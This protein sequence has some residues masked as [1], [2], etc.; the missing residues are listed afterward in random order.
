[1]LQRRL[2]SRSAALLCSAM[3]LTPIAVSAQEKPMPFDSIKAAAGDEDP[4]D[5]TMAKLSPAMKSADI[6]AAIKKVADWQAG[7]SQAKFNQDWTYAPLYLGLLAASKTTGDAKYHDAV[8]QASEKFQ[9]KLWAT[10]QFHAD[11]EAIGQAYEALYVEKKDPVRIADTKATFDRLLQRPDDPQKDLWWWCDALFM[12]PAGM[13]RMSAITGN[14]AYLDKMDHEWNLTTEHL[15][16]KGEH[17]YFRDNSYIGKTEKNGQKIFWGRGNGW[18]LGGLANTIT[19][20]DKNDPLRPKYVALFREMSERVAGLQQPDGLWH[21]GLLDQQ[22]YALPEISGSAFFTYAFAWGVNQG[23]LDRAK[24]APVV[25]KAWA[26]M[27]QHVYADGRLGCI[28]PIGAAPGAFGPTSSY[29]YGVG[30]F[31]LAGAE[32]DRMAAHGGAAAKHGK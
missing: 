5:T 20:M 17:L 24:Y 6:R 7:H 4:G 22:A 8:L 32:L 30:A 1:M 28:Q 25:E 10:R 19:A 2:L 13:A 21:S 18:V 14:R 26:G 23:I 9:W 29:V 11:D 12:A 15:Y 16:D 31:L 27:L 3:L